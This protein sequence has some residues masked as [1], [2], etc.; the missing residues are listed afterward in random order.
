MRL[1]SVA[2]PDTRL[3]RTQLNRIV[4]Y[5][6]FLAAHR[7]I[8][9]IEKDLDLYVPLQMNVESRSGSDSK[10]VVHEGPQRREGKKEKGER[11]REEEG[12]NFVL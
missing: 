7:S 10:A 11:K 4:P 1:R 8:L 9:G 12:M 5:A 3:V 6:A 2:T